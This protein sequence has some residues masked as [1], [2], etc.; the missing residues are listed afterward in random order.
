MASVA[1]IVV[2]CLTPL[3]F[4]MLML[5]YPPE[6]Y[7]PYVIATLVISVLILWSLRPNI[8]RIFKGTERKVDY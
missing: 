2:A 6:Q 8:R 1:S 5:V 4:A 7:L 3:A